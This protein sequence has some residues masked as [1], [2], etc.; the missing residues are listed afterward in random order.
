MTFL[1]ALKADLERVVNTWVKT[2]MK[3]G[4][5]MGKRKDKGFNLFV[6][7]FIKFYY[8]DC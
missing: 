3:N 5:T 8:S 1:Y 6:F 2:R 4:L 7:F